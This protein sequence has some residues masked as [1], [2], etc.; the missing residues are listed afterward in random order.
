MAAWLQP[1]LQIFLLGFLKLFRFYAAHLRIG[2]H[3]VLVK[4]MSLSILPG[5]LAKRILLAL[6]ATL[7][8]VYI[9]DSLW[10]RVHMIHPKQADPLESFTGPRVLAIPEKGGKTSYANR[11][12]TARANNNLCAFVV[13]TRGISALLVCQAADESANSDV[14][15]L[16]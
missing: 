11:P 4:G 9:G 8:V 1:N 15:Q 7:L 5:A 12:A 13:S 14:T 6:V 10:F 2:L 3:S 16:A